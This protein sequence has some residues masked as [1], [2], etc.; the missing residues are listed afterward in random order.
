MKKYICNDCGNK[1]DYIDLTYHDYSHDYEGF[2][3]R[4]IDN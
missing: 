1:L 3:T 2:T 4:E